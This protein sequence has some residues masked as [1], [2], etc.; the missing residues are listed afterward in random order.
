MEYDIRMVSTYPPRVCGIGNFAANLATALEQFSEIRKISVAAISK[1]KL[2]Y[3][4]PVDLVID[5]YDEQSWQRAQLDILKRANQS[6]NPTVV[7]LQ[8]E[9][10]IDGKEGKGNNYAATA[11]KVHDEGHTIITYLHTILKN[12]NGHQKTALQELAENSDGLVVTTESAIDLLK[13]IYGIDPSKVRHIDHGIRIRDIANDRFSIKNRYNLEKKF[14]VTTLGL[15]SPDKGLHYG[16]SAYA[17]FIAESCTKKQR[18]DIS[19]LIA[20]QFHPEFVKADNGIPYREYREILNQAILDSKLKFCESGDLARCDFEKNDIIFLN[21]HLE[22][23]LLMQLYGATNVMVLPYCNKEQISSGILA[24]TFGSGRVAIATKN[25]YAC[26]LIGLYNPDKEGAIIT[27]RGILVDT[28]EPCIEQIGQGL[29]YLVFNPK[30][31]IEME[32]NIRERGYDMRWDN[33]AWKLMQYIGFIKEDKEIITGRG[34]EF[35]RE[36]DS[37]LTIK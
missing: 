28:L 10:G 11:K 30:E 17:R 33:S 21:E 13:S 14:L 35:V 32:R 1:E 18:E 9:Y 29:D 15:L 7:L 20:G 24:D 22:E 6:A 5:Q 2:A 27:P 3:S 26:E 8:H 12:P 19:Y 36:K 37:E 23:N 25:M 31:R 4:I 34:P 16:I